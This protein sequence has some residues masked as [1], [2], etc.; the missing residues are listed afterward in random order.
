MALKFP[1]FRRS[2]RPD[3]VRDAYARIVEQARQPVFYAVAGVPDTVD[4]RFELIALHAFLVLN[5]LKA[6]H[7]EVGN[8]GARDFGQRLFDLMFADMDQA[9]REMGVGDLGVGREVKRMAK[10]FFGRVAAYEAGLRG[11]E[12]AQG[13]VLHEALRRNLFGTADSAAAKVEPVAAYLREAA[14]L[15]AGIEVA[16]IVAGR[17]RFPSPEL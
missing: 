15:L 17:V 6:G 2:P 16:E 1:F 7:D 8:F 5:R 14:S 9:L 10:A 13:E 4:G 12:G 11:G 3:P